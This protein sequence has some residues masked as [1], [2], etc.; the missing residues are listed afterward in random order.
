MIVI[1]VVLS[2]IASFVNATAIVMQRRASGERPPS[3]L[4]RKKLFVLVA[5]KRLWLASVGLQLLGFLLQAAALYW[6]SLILVEPIMTMVLVFLFLLLHFRYNIPASMREWLAIGF[7][8]VGLIAM[9]SAARPHGGNLHYSSSVWALT[10]G[11]VLA[12]IAVCIAIVRRS[13]SPKIRAAVGGLAAAANI[14]MTA[15]LAKLAI[16]RFGE[17]PVSLLW[18]WELYALIVSG[19]LMVVVLQSVFAAGPLVI[20]QPI[21]EIVNPIVSGTI[22]I[23]VFH[24]V[25]NTSAAAISVAIP[26]LV[27][28][29]IGLS[30]IGGSKRY[31][32]TH[33]T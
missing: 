30:L 5:K 28:A 22:A 26:G 25:I 3:E 21:I 32:R 16:V 31:E 12:T 27:L 6:G 1:V 33:V 7:V 15:A 14:G 23:V 17:N 9:L 20:S 24:N 19:L 8:C 29:I 4:F 13:D 11:V 10:I 2:L 18:S